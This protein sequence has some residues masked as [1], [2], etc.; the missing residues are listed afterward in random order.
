MPPSSLDQC[1]VLSHQLKSF[2]RTLSVSLIINI[3]SQDKSTK[4]E[5]LRGFAWGRALWFIGSKAL[6]ML[7]SLIAYRLK[8][9]GI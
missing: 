9:L 1:E 8:N 3:L 7:D 5:Y 6:F 4:V 2:P